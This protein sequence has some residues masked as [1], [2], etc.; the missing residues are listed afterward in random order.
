MYLALVTL[1]KRLLLGRVAEGEVGLSLSEQ[2]TGLLSVGDHLGFQ[3]PRACQ[4]PLGQLSACGWLAVLGHH[5]T[6]E[7][8]GQF[9]AGGALGRPLILQEVFVFVRVRI[10]S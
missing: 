1:V 7:G 5:A 9:G 4:V 2:Q 8:R 6:Q 3:S 10:C